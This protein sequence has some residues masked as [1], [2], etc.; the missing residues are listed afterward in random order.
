MKI[1]AFLSTSKIRYAL[2]GFGVGLTLPMGAFF[3]EAVFQGLPITF[4]TLVYLHT[5]HT[6]MW[7]IDMAPLFLGS[8]LGWVGWQHE[9]LTKLSADLDHRLAERTTQLVL[10]NDKLTEDME[11]LSRL[12]ENAERGK[13]EWEAIFDSVLDLIF[14]VDSN[15]LIVRFNRAVMDTFKSTFTEIDRKPLLELLFPEDAPAELKL[16]RQSIPRLGKNYEVFAKSLELDPD[17]T[18]TIYVLHDVTELIREKK[19]FEALNLTSPVAI[20]VLDDL[21]TIISCNPAFEQLYGYTS[22]EITGKHLDT[23]IAT[24]ETIEEARA[25]SKNAMTGPIHG[26]GKRCR[27]DGK[28]VTVEI[29]GSPVVI[30][31]HKVGTLAIYHDITELDR[32]R[33]DAEQANLAK[34]EFLANMSHE[35]RTPLNGVIGMLEL[36]LNTSLTDE[37]RDYLKISWQSAKTLL[38]LINDILDFSKIE[39]HQLKLENIDFDVRETVEDLAQIMAIQAQ[40][41]GL[42]LICL[43]HPNLESALKGDPGRLRQ[44]LVNL[45]GNAIKFTHQGEIIIRVELVDETA[46]HATI[47]FSVQDTGIGI[48]QE[49]LATIF[50]RFVQ[51]DGSTTRKY[52]GTGLGLIISK[53]LVKAM[54]GEI[55]VNSELGNGSTFWFTVGLE[56]QTEM[57]VDKERHLPMIPSHL[58]KD[59]HL[60]VVDDNVT[61]CKEIAKMAASFSCRADIALSGQHG[62]TILRSAWRAGDPFRILLLDLQMPVMNGEQTIHQIRNDPDICDIQIIMLISMSQRSDLTRLCAAGC[63]AYLVKPVQQH[64]LYKALLSTITPTL[65]RQLHQS[66]QI[67]SSEHKWQELRI[68]LVEDNPINQKLV[69]ILLQKAGVYV[70]AVENGRRAVEKVQNERYDIVLMDVQMPDMDGLEATRRIRLWETGQGRRIPIIAMTAHA[71]SGDQEICLAAGMDDYI[72]KPM[73]SEDLFNAI[74]RWTRTTAPL[75]KEKPVIDNQDYSDFLEN[76]ADELDLVFEGELFQQ[77]ADEKPVPLNDELPINLTTALPRFF[78]SRE[79]FFEMCQELIDQIPDRVREINTALQTHDAKN[80]LRAAHNLKG[81][82]ANFSADA[83]SRVAAQ[84]EASGNSEDTTHIASLVKLLEV[85]VERLYQ[86]CE[87]ELDIKRKTNP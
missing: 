59:L 56:K 46:T 8:L 70:D 36:T 53:E 61:N 33:K 73:E 29:F 68:L 57:P 35:I 17:T 12:E 23:L 76:S 30:E 19:F 34:S 5:A 39:A 47:L 79:L 22:A 81:V 15:G 72:S 58:L 20:V 74:E 51:A 10:A 26:T 55:G 65:N 83:V 60:L 18:H 40:E 62:L 6:L 86:Y 54:H 49:Q 7:L 84:I 85:E 21:D 28:M 31:N 77:P 13:E 14:M 52:G 50:A 43:L 3:I 11:I 80:L 37:Q 69:I 45:I 2:V 1:W 27:K 25:Y 78:N 66:M 32:A 24:P 38:A 44:V 67:L 75:Q 63:S 4:S 42:E 71:L 16:G 82:S 87:S 41:K 9:Q 64:L 48:P